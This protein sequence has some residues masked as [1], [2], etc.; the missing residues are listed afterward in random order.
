MPLFSYVRRVRHKESSTPRTPKAVM[1]DRRSVVPNKPGKG[2]MRRNPEVRN[3]F[4]HTFFIPKF[5][6]K[7]ILIA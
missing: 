2:D 3:L 4:N 7:H 5:I 6:P 1:D